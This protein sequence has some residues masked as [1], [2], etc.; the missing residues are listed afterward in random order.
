MGAGQEETRSSAGA[1]CVCERRRCECLEAEAPDHTRSFKSVE[2]RGS[3]SAETEVQ[4]V[5]GVR[6]IHLC[7]ASRNNLQF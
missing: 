7:V 3:S 6:N 2:A 4:K 5:H 1:A